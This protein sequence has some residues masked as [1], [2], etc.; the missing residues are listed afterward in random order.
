MAKIAFSGFVRGSRR[1][2]DERSPIELHDVLY[3]PDIKSLHTLLY[4]LH[5]NADFDLNYLESKIL[6]NV[7]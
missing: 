1:S 3:N 2:R 6:A 7:Q 5:T 4:L